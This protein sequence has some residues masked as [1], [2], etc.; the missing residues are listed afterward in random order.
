MALSHGWTPNW[1]L[2]D[3]EVARVERRLGRRQAARRGD[4]EGHGQQAGQHDDDA[5]RQVGVG[6]GHHAAE[7]REQDDEGRGD[8]GARRL[9]DLAVGDDVDDEPAGDELVGDDG[10]EGHDQGDGPE[11]PRGRPVPDLE[12]VARPCTARRCGSWRPGSR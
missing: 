5:V 10:D 6:D 11:E 2:T 12:D 8:E 3:G 7:G 9:R 4:D 1:L